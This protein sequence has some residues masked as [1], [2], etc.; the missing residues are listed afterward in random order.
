M[1]SAT[2]SPLPYYREILGGREDDQLLSLDSP[3]ENK[4]LCVMLANRVSTKYHDR[5]QSKQPIV[6]LIRSFMQSKVGNYMIY[7]PSY[8]YMD[9]IYHEFIRAYP[10]VAVLKQET[11]MTEQEREH[12]LAHFQKNP[13]RSLIGFCVLGG[14]FSEGIDLKGS[15]LIGAAIVSVGL[16]QLSVQQNIIRDYFNHKNGLGFE[17]AY[18]YPGMNKVQ[19]AAGRVIRSESD[20][21][22]VL[23]IDER[24]S[25]KN[26]MNLFPKHWNPTRKVHDFQSLEKALASFWGHHRN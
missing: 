23:L 16:P 10:D 21:G 18:M 15:R 17:Y 26:Y 22:A 3:F 14:I 12:F 25:Y 2:L 5:E 6:R 13:S 24:F 1:F 19:Q 9:D 4:R 8:Q 7:F 11:V 20:V